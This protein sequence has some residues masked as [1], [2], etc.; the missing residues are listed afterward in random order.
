MVLLR[1]GNKPLR[2]LNPA[3][4]RELIVRNLGLEHVVPAAMAHLADDPFLETQHYAGDLLTAVLEANTRFWLDNE[5][6]WWDMIP[7]LER[8]VE[9]INARILE[10][11][12]EEYLPWRLGDEFMAALLHFRSIHGNSDSGE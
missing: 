5:P 1:L 11:G 8:A 9:R 3:E 12:S 4:L 6:L 10:E 7:I 2:R